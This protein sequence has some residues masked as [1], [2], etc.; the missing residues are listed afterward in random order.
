[1]RPLSLLFPLLSLLLIG[2]GGEAET[3]ALTGTKLAEFGEVPEFELVDCFGEPFTRQDM[4]GKVWIVDFIFTS[5]PS[6]CPLMT[7]NM[8]TLSEL[9][10]DEEDV[11]LLSITVDPET[12]TP[13]VLKR[14]ADLYR[15]D[16]GRWKWI[17]GERTA[18]H[19]LIQDGFFLSMGETRTAQPTHSTRY[20]VVDRRGMIRSYHDQQSDDDPKSGVLRDVR[21]LLD[22]P[23][24]AGEGATGGAGE[25]GSIG[26]EEG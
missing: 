1:M 15:A 12:D 14:F 8:K 11:R 5:C 19:A 22:A 2:C 17:T 21:L 16:H 7:T 20:V 25:R 3:S 26:G 23:D 10:G 9:L 18:L 6:A 13:E 4:L 24:E